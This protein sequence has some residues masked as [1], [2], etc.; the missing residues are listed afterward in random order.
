[1][2]KYQPAIICMLLCGNQLA[3][4]TPFCAPQ[5]AQGQYL[6]ITVMEIDEA[7]F[8]RHGGA[9]EISRDQLDARL[10][11]SSGNID[12]QMT[13]DFQHQYTDFTIAGVTPGPQTNGDM[14]TT[15]LPVHWQNRATDRNRRLSVAPVLATSSNGL[16]N[17]DELDENFLQLWLSW[18]DQYRWRGDSYWLI[19]LC[20]DHRFDHFR[21][22]PVLGIAGEWAAQNQYRL[23]F[24]DSYV[25]WVFSRG[26]SSFLRIGP[27]GG[28]WR[29]LD[30]DLDR[31]SDFRWQ[32]WQA[33]AEVR[34]QFGSRWRAALSLGRVFDQQLRFD[35]VDNSRLS[36]DADD[37]SYWRLEFVYQR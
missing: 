5:L 25:S 28:E 17:P 26:F 22:T 2:T 15:S 35:R 11:H 18:E 20:G 4:A 27:A 16:E 14:H 31:Q 12:W 6:G 34:W 23:A 24:P 1:M 32:A 13:V 37:S 7:D 33:E 8:D 29:I 30:D 9:V 10:V 21:I 3:F 19:G 36:T